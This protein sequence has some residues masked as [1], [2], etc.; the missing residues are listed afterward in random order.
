MGAGGVGMNAVQGAAAAGAKHVV[1]I[2]PVKAKREWAMDF[3]A[4]HT[5]ETA[6]QA[7]AAVVDLT[8]R[9]R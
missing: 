4:T 7:T 6:E 8:L 3:G 1:V 5:F 9:A 2:D